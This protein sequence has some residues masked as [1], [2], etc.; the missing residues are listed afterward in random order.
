M[1]I[2]RAFSARNFLLDVQS[3]P[4]SDIGT[5]SARTEAETISRVTATISV[6]ASYINA[7]STAVG[8]SLGTPF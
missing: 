7:R 4:E 8:R 3:A 6:I 5:A 1:K 2:A